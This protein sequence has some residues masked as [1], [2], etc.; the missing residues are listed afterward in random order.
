MPLFCRIFSI[1]LGLVA[2]C[3]AGGCSMWNAPGPAGQPVVA[4]EPVFVAGNDMEPVWERVVDVL[5]GYQFEIAR[6]NKLDGVIET[7]YKVGAGLTEPWHR[8]SVGFRNRLESTL[9]SIR[10]R[11]FVHVTPANGGYLVSV[12]AYKELENL[13]GLAAN[14]AGGATF[15]E[16]APLQR[17]LNVVVGQ[18]AP[19]GWVSHGRDLALERD[20][21]ARLKVAFGR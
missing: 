18:T 7:K 17:D 4:S 2:V 1:I 9:Q 10:R 14:S 11:V 3:T 19:S 16:N 15:Q 12:V 20:M 21:T 8:D 13:V 6:Q 5:H